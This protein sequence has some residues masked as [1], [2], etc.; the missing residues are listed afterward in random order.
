MFA[1]ELWEHFFDLSLCQ[2]SKDEAIL[3][4]RTTRINVNNLQFLKLKL[5]NELCCWHIKTSMMIEICIFLISLF[6][7]F[8]LVYFLNGP[9]IR[10]AAKTD[11]IH[12]KKCD[13][14]KKAPR[15][16][17][18]LSISF[19]FCYVFKCQTRFKEQKRK[20]L[21]FAFSLMWK[22]YKTYCVCTYN[23]TTRNDELSKSNEM[24]SI[25]VEVWSCSSLMSRIAVMGQGIK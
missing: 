16:H 25:W 6:G 18:D 22:K 17:I 15:L 20:Y 11:Q 3:S 9:R 1:I 21:Y 24:F 4:P 19:L 7:A 5:N 2:L 12:A 13:E 23:E 10:N 14:I 8:S